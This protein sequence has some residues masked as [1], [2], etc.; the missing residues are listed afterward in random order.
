MPDQRPGDA[1][2]WQAFGKRLA[3]VGE[4]AAAAGLGFAWH[5]HDFEFKPLADGSI[6][7][8]HILDSAPGVG[9]EIDVAWV[10]RG[11]AD[12]LKWINDYASRI[13]AVHVK[14][15]APK[16]EAADEDGSTEYIINTITAAPAGTTWAVGTEINLVRRLQSRMPDKTIFCLDPVICPCSTMYRI[17][18]A[19]ILWAL[20]HLERGDVVNQIQVEEPTRSNALIALNRMLALP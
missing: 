6:P 13:V 7:L 1:A 15:I 3:R 14:D 4:A 12:P 20:E 19:Y 8:K 10:V 18:T 11:G 5:N 9:W 2:G 17:H 16:G